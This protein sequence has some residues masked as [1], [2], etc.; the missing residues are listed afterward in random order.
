M[1]F[2]HKNNHYIS[3]ITRKLL[4]LITPELEENYR[5]YF[6]ILGTEW[7]FKS[8]VSTLWKVS[9]SI[10]RQKICRCLYYTKY[11]IPKTDTKNTQKI[12]KRVEKEQSTLAFENIQTR[13][14]EKYLQLKIH[15]NI[16]KQIFRI[17]LSAWP[18]CQMPKLW[19]STNFERGKVLKIEP[20]R[21]FQSP[22]KLE[23]KF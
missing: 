6:E 23:L 22:F 16:E 19:E 4:C 18:S 12:E 20:V 9:K 1:K 14:L 8:Y 21:H 5:G 7:Q 10:F 11:A 13:C 17:I 3:H 15:K 2:Q